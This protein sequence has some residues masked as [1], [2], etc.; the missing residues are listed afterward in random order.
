MKPSFSVWCMGMNDGGDTNDTTPA[1]GW[2]TNTQLFLTLCETH[3]ITPILATIP[4]VPNINHTT[5]IKS[6]VLFKK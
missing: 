4:T 3:G 6:I 2:L 1:S 5:L